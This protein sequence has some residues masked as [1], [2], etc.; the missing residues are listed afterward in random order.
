MNENDRHD[1]VIGKSYF[2]LTFADKD[3]KFPMILSLVFLG[4]NIESE[5]DENELWFFQDAKSYGEFGDYR[6]VAHNKDARFEIYDF[7]QDGL[8]DVLTLKGLIDALTKE[9]KRSE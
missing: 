2:M 3:F 7:P 1:F 5:E 4:K 9:Q 6:K 8:C